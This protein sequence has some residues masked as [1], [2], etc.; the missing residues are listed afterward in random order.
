LPTQLTM[1]RTNESYAAVMTTANNIQTAVATAITQGKAA[2]AS[3]QNNGFDVTSSGPLTVGSNINPLPVAFDQTSYDNTNYVTSPTLFTIQ[4][5]GLYM[6]S[7]TVTWNKGPAGVRTLLVMQNSTIVLDE[8]Q[9]NV[10]SVGPIT[11]NF[12]VIQQLNAGDTLQVLV[13]Q[14]TG[15]STN[16]LM[17]AEFSVLLVPTSDANPRPEFTDVASPKGDNQVRQLVADTTMGSGVAVQI[18]PNGGV[19][20]VDPVGAVATPFVDGIVT[21][22]VQATEL[23]DVGT[24]Y[25][26][27]YTIT[28]AHFAVGGLLYA[29]PGGVLTQN[30][31]T[32]ITQ[33]NWIIVVGRAIGPNMMLFEPQIPTKIVPM[34]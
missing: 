11:Q 15:V 26:S 19:L 25:G 17:G 31:N 7:G 33:V 2:L 1:L 12:S 23:A 29:G 20:P 27:L 16:I 8:Q 4:V 10:L 28:G 13:T 6:L 30:Y 34:I 5:T 32:L 21:D 22:A 9:T 14:T 18:Q 24:S 3:I